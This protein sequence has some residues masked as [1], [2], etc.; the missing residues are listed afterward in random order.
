MDDSF[1]SWYRIRLIHLWMVSTRLLSDPVQG[2]HL[3]DGLMNSFYED[4]KERLPKLGVSDIN[5]RAAL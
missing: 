2:V 3:R 1:A 5:C 4:A